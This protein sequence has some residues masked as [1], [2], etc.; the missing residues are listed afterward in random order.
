MPPQPKKVRGEN[1]P[2]CFAMRP[3]DGDP[4]ACHFEW[5]LDTDLK[6]K[7]MKCSKTVW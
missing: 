7:F 6:V 2:G 3:I 4:K 5:L 1:G